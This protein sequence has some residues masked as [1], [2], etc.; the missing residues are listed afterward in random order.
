MDTKLYMSVL[1]D[2]KRQIEQG[3][4]QPSMATYAVAKQEELS[5]SDVETAYALSAPW[6]AGVGTVSL[7]SHA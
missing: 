3:T 2:V 7:I 5:L 1:D 6:A 4:A